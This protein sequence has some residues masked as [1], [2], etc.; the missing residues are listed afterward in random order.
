MRG[1]GWEWGSICLQTPEQRSLVLSGSSIS[2][3][4]NLLVEFWKPI[5]G[6][7]VGTKMVAASLENATGKPGRIVLKVTQESL[8]MTQL[9]TSKISVS[10]RS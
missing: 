8:G 6:V 1:E 4:S 7:V 5:D 10:F 3:F 2:C 9:G